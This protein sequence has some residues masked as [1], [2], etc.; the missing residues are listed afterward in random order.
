MLSAHTMQCLLTLFVCFLLMDR[1]VLEFWVNKRFLH[2]HF[3]KSFLKINWLC[4]VFALLKN[5]SL[6]YGGVT[7][8]GEGVHNLGLWSELG[9]FEQG[10]IFIVLH[11]M[12]N[13]ASGFFCFIRRSRLLRHTRI[14]GG[15]ILTRVLVGTFWGEMWTDLMFAPKLVHFC[16]VPT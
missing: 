11:L 12:W 10:G 8:T 4:I 6:L 14:C 3:I 5:F 16:P 7:I 2:S 9:S 15:S 1:N 13:G